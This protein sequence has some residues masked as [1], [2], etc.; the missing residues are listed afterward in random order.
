MEKE[1]GLG[2]VG[3]LVDV[4]INLNLGQLTSTLDM[5]T[6]AL[7]ETGD[8][9]KSTISEAVGKLREA[10]A[11][12]LKKASEKEGGKGKATEAY[13]RTVAELQIAKDKGDKE[14][15]K[16]LKEMKA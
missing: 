15:A 4:D 2:N 12:D 1:K 7:K 9:A 13:H 14:A 11:P 6:N 8:K 3:G 10:G 5:L 16:L